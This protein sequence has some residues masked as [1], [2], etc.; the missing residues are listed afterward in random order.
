M[1]QD[2]LTQETLYSQVI[3]ECLLHN[4]AKLSSPFVLQRKLE[5]KN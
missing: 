2:S 3:F 4:D 1:T 5:Y